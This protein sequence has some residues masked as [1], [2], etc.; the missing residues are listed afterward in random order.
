MK[1]FKRI[2]ALILAV[3]CVSVCSGCLK[4]T[5]NI[6]DVTT[7]PSFTEPTE[8][9]TSHQQTPSYPYVTEPSTL[10]PEIT[11]LPEQTTGLEPPTTLP[12][13]SEPST[14][15][16]V[17][18]TEVPT[19][20]AP[21]TE[22]P[23]TQAAEKDPSQWSK[24]ETLKF[25]T[26]AMNKSR[27]VTTPLTVHHSEAFSFTV[28]DM[29]DKV[30]GIVN[31]VIASVAKPSDETLQFN[32]GKATNSEGE[33]V[34]L[35]LPKKGNFYLDEAGCTSIS[36]SK[37]GNDV[38]IKVNLIE[39]KVDMTTPP[40]YNS[41]ACGYLDTAS[42][43]LPSIIKISAFDIDYQG[44]TITYTINS[45][46]YCS[47]AAYHVLLG[48]DIAGSGMGIKANIK[49]GGYEDEVWEVNW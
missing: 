21:V 16:Q 41:S 11:T 2:I 49:I 22:A 34:P 19:S 42:L 46:G 7:A 36:A 43:D 24:A 47:K 28:S 33:V 23:T 1:K 45:D 32:G 48:L 27:A 29:N 38:I 12:G 37:S 18:T 14:A 17:P 40:K 31:K 4:Y 35:L 9:T 20:G 5:S 44:T 13:V 6:L 25:L 10:Y 39:E 30:A 26:D 3:L 8:P 15:P